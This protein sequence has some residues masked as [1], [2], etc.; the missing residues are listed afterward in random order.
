MIFSAISFRVPMASMVTTHPFR[1]R[2]SNSSGIAL[3]SFVFSSTRN[4]PKTRD[5]SQAHALTTWEGR[6]PLLSS[7][8]RRMVFPSMAIIPSIFPATALVHRKK[9]SWNWS[10]S[11]IWN[12][13][14]IVSWEGIPPG[15]SRNV[16]SHSFLE[17]AQSS[18]S[19]QVSIPQRIAVTAMMI[20]SRNLC[21]WLYGAL[22]SGTSF[23]HPTSESSFPISVIIMISFQ[24]VME[25][26]VHDCVEIV[27]H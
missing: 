18:I 5:V 15:S 6:F 24:E 8:L 25:I 22:G 27:S 21:L 13:R 4:C 11:I 1:H 20:I 7:L 17:Y 12:T 2:I 3:I 16:S 10:G 26:I 9:A 19:F 23:I 14:L